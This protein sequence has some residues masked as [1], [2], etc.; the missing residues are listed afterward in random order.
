MEA[1]ILGAGGHAKVLI[2]CLNSTGQAI[3]ILGVLDVNRKLHRQY[4]LILPILGDEDEI[5]KQY[6]HTSV[7]L[8]NGIGST[9][10]TAMRRSIFMKFKNAGFN[11]INIMHASAY[12]SQA[13]KVGEGVQMI[14][15]STVH[16]GSSI[17]NNVILNT[18]AVIDHDCVIHDHV[19]IAPGVIC[20]G[21][22]SIG[23]GTHIGSGA[24]I[25]QGI[26]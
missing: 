18:H 14:T 15:R 7:K 21:N 17:G 25:L 4:L 2:D 22:V 12:L 6:S 5:L 23:E 26:T 1:F 24:V 13:A 19:H 10:N 11:F 9:G 8:I 3:N 16:P 20:G